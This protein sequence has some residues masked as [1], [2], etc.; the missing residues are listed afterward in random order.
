MFLHLS[1]SHPVNRGGSTSVH[2]GIPPGTPGTR[3]PPEQTPSPRDQVPPWEQTPPRPGTPPQCMLGDMVNKRAVCILL[4]C[5]LV[6]TYF[7]RA[8]RG[9]WPPR[10]PCNTFQSVFVIETVTKCVLFIVIRTTE[11]KWFHHPFCPLFT[12]SPLTLTVAITDIG[13]KSY[14]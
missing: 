10:S 2:A 13:L 5:N 9:L 6:M 4:E 1:V 8:R 11:R 12:P 7:C 3:Y 14:V